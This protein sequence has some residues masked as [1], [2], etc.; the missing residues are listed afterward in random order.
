MTANDVCGS[1]DGPKDLTQWTDAYDQML[2]NVTSNYRNIYINLMSTLDLSDVARLQR[3]VRFCNLE[4]RLLLKEC[5]CIDR[6]N[7]SQLKTLDE[8]VHAMNAQL[9]SIASKWMDKLGTAKRDDVA[10]VYQPYLEGIGP[11]LDISFLNRLDCFHPAA[12]AHE[13]L[14][15]GLWASMLCKDRATACGRK[16][17]ETSPYCATRNATFYVPP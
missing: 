13:Q 5:G 2:T 14:A 16:F 4:H 7:S 12:K 11:N 17:P 3:S 1:C 8:N 10:V 15:M 9:S 6:G